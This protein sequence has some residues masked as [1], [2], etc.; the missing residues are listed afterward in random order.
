MVNQSQRPILNR[1][2]A[3]EPLNVGGREFS[4]IDDA[5]LAI[6]NRMSFDDVALALDDHGVTISS[7]QLRRWKEEVAA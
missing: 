3:L 1:L 7:R 4:S 2:L 6:G 5:L